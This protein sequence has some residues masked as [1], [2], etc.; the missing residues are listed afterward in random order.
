MSIR[1]GTPATSYSS[2]RVF[3]HAG[4]IAKCRD[5]H[6]H[7]VYGL[8]QSDTIA[9]P[10]GYDRTTTKKYPIINVPDRIKYR[11]ILIHKL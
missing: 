4:V 11:V 10:Q 8:L 3:V 1:P 6:I 9:S 5:V 7:R 2:Y